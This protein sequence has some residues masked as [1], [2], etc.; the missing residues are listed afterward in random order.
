MAADVPVRAV[1]FDLDDTLWPVGPAIERA[2][3]A[4]HRWLD[5]PCPGVAERYTIECVR[6]LREAVAEDYPE[7]A[8]DF[9][10]LRRATLARLLESLGETLDLDDHLAETAYQVFFAARNDVDLFDGVLP[11]LDALSQR[12]RL[13]CISNGNAD[14][15]VIGIGHYFAVR[16]HAADV[17][18]AKPHPLPFRTVLEAFE[19]EPGE[20]VH[21]GDCLHADVGGAVGAGCRAVWFNPDHREG[22]VPPGAIEID[23]LAQLPD[24]IASLASGASR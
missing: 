16:V 13:A 23:A 18:Q 12:H 11:L 3:R 5:R 21:V 4:L 15:D 2:E 9:A 24:V 20:L 6:R 1:S 22:A 8:H 19:L 10:F 14:V 7:R 17:G